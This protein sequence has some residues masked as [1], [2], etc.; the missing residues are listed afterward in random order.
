MKK[1]YVV[2]TKTMGEVP[3][4]E[5]VGHKYNYPD[6]W[7]HSVTEV[8][9]L[10]ECV[11]QYPGRQIFTIDGYNQYKAGVDMVEEFLPLANPPAAPA[12]RPW[13]KIWGN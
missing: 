1:N 11:E 6:K 12:K 2:I 10:K 13:W 7:P 5:K 3:A 8:C 9:S 4:E